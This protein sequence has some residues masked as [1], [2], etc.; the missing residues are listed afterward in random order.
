MNWLASIAQ[1]IGYGLGK[2]LYEAWN[3]SRGL[4]EETPTDLDKARADR[5]NDAIAEFMRNDGD[6]VQDRSPPPGI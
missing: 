1:G 4:V 3:E 6:T 5:L 2:G